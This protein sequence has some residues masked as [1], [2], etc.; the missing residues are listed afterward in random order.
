MVTTECIPRVYQ[1]HVLPGSNVAC[2]QQSTRK[3]KKDEHD[4][5]QLGKTEDLRG[6][7]QLA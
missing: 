1:T 4:E 2:Q 3:K 6:M 5:S 7:D